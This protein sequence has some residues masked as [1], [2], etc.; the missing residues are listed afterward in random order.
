[1]QSILNKIYESKFLNE[2]ESYKLFK[3]IASGKIN[4]IQLSS[5]LTA[6]QMRGESEEEILGAINAFSERMK[7]FPRPNYIFL[8]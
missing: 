2:K 3:E 5:I 6:M 8:I 7:F 4:E 1:M